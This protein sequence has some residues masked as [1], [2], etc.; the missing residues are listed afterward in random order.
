MIVEQIMRSDILNYTK[1]AFN[2]LKMI[3]NDTVFSANQTGDDRPLRKQSAESVSP[4]YPTDRLLEPL[5]V[6]NRR[7]P[8]GDDATALVL[9]Q[10][11]EHLGALDH[12]SLAHQHPLKVTGTGA[13][14]PGRQHTVFDLI[15]EHALIS[16]HPPFFI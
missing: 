12:L 9:P 14:E 16:G 11:E 10:V 13:V 4:T 2:S 8:V 3:Q 7:E 6:L 5:L 15:S 1:L